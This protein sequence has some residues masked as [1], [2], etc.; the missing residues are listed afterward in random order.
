MLDLVIT[1]D[2]VFPV[3]VWAA[4]PLQSGS[5]SLQAK[6]AESIPGLWSSGCAGILL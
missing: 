5:V 1:H 6:E 2:Y 3:C 4:G